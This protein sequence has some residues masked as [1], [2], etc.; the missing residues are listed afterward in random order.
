MEYEKRSGE[1]V[2]E[3]VIQAVSLAENCSPRELPT[4]Y[5]TIDTDALNNIFEPIGGNPTDSQAGAV[6]FEYFGY[7]ITAH[8]T[9]IIKVEPISDSILVEQ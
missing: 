6:V 4:L 1:T 7:C 8:S 3:A 5:G 2:T 9:G